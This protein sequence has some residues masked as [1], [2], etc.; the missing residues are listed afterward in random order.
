M[1]S[2]R[3]YLAKAPDY[4][5]HH[6]CIR[7]AEGGL[8]F[9][10]YPLSNMQ[11]EAG[12]PSE[13]CSNQRDLLEERIKGVIGLPKLAVHIMHHPSPFLGEVTLA[14]PILCQF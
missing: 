9:V 14:I 5:R 10:R 8:T 3:V 11:L 12:T 6:P 1:V 4:E 13:L 7:I 2:L